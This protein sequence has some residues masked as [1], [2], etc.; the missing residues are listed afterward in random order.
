LH[1]DSSFLFPKAHDRKTEETSN[2][3]NTRRKEG[4]FGDEAFIYDPVQNIYRC[5]A[6][7][8]LKP[9]RVHPIRRTLE[10]KASASICGNCVLRVQCTRSSC[11]HTVQRHEKQESLD[12]ARAQ[13]N[14]PAARRNRKRR[15]HL[16]E[17]SFADASNN[18]HFKRARWRRLWRQQIQDCLIAAIQNVRILLAHPNPK[19]SAAAALV[20]PR[21]SS[22]S[23]LYPFA[24]LRSTAKMQLPAAPP[25]QHSRDLTNPYVRESY[26]APVT[27]PLSNTPFRFDPL[28]PLHGRSV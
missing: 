4:I 18:H 1:R 9:R 21:I 2:T 25:F 17:C 16:M 28:F 5:P 6:G 7:Q 12:R 11:G 8:M 23:F 10:Y 14:S 3:G 19:R 27:N 26:W 15:Q 20:A 13:A 24:S 22:I